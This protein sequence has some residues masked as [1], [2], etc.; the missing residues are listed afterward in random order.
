MRRRQEIAVDNVSFV[1]SA[2]VGVGLGIVFSRL[3]IRGLLR[4]PSRLVLAMSFVVL[5]C[6]GVL[7][8]AQAERAEPALLLVGRADPRL[9]LGLCT[10]LMSATVDL[11]LRSNPSHGPEQ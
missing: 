2:A 3:L 11:L 5:V 7:T 9:V 6:C 8:I 10:A 1:A 4:R